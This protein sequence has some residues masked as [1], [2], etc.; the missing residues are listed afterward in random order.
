MLFSKYI[1][2][3]APLRHQSGLKLCQFPPESLRYLLSGILLLLPLTSQSLFSQSSWSDPFKQNSGHISSLFRTLQCPLSHKV[4]YDLT[5]NCPLS[6]LICYHSSSLPLHQL[7]WSLLCSM[8]IPSVP[9]PHG[10]G[11]CCSRC[12]EHWSLRHL[13]RSLCLSL[14][15]SHHSGS[16]S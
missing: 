14:Q 8:I 16:L 10:L 11:T 12:L 1:Q 9:L 7:Q 5:P 13:Y 15:L 6:V 4:S 3:S 2:N